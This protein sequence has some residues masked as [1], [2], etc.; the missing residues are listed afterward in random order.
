MQ[1]TA[2]LESLTRTIIINKGTHEFLLSAAKH[3]GNY[4]NDMVQYVNKVYRNIYTEWSGVNTITRAQWDP[5][6][7]I[8]DNKPWGPPWITQDPVGLTLSWMGP[9]VVIFGGFGFGWVENHLS[10][11]SICLKMTADFT[12]FAKV[13]GQSEGLIWEEFEGHKLAWY[14]T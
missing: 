14:S 8:Q 6:W 3:I 9:T 2:V 4:S 10:V 5:P 12:G 11:F 7:S 13:S 1:S